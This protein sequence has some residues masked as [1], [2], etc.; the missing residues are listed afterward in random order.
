MR[1]ASPNSILDTRRLPARLT[2]EQ[3]AVLLGFQLH[4]LPILIQKGLLKPLGT[5]APNAPKYYAA[6]EIEALA[7]DSNWL[8]R[9]TKAVSGRWAAKNK[10]D[11]SARQMAA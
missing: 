6:C 2:A 7:G 10:A 5:P 9:A 11:R 8:H 4:D 1:T 3:A